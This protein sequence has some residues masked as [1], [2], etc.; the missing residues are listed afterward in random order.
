M[1]KC[2]LTTAVCLQEVSVSK[3]QGS[4][5]LVQLPN[6]NNSS[7]PL[8]SC[9]ILHHPAQ[10]QYHLKVSYHFSPPRN[11]MHLVSNET[12]L[13]KTRCILFLSRTTELCSMDIICEKLAYTH[14]CFEDFC[15]ANDC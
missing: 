5:L 12:H 13:I 14:V 6:E 11:E 1:T 10:L 4:V 8:H 9:S 2:L 7:T 3:L 15:F